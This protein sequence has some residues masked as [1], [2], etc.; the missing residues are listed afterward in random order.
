VRLPDATTL[1]VDT[2]GLG[3]RSSFDIG[4]RVV[5]P[6]IWARGV[7]VSTGCC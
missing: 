1:L 3:G 5:A 2:G 7:G 6:A 4:A